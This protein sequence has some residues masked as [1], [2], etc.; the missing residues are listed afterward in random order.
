MEESLTMNKT[1]RALSDMQKHSA[2]RAAMLLTMLTVAITAWAQTASTDDGWQVIGKNE[3]ECVI[4]G[5]DTFNHNPDDVTVFPAIIDGRA[6]VEINSSLLEIFKN[7]ETVY[8]YEGYQH[9]E[10]PSLVR[11]NYF[12]P[13]AHIHIVNRSGEIVT[14]DAIPTSITKIPD[15]TFLD[16]VSLEKLTLPDGLKY[17]GN[18]AFNFCKALKDINIPDGVTNIGEYAFERCEALTS[19]SIPSSVTIIGEGAFSGCS[20]LT[21]VTIPNSVTSI[22]S[23]A[24]ELCSGLTSVTIPNSVTNIESLAFSQCSG[25]T[26]VTIPNSVTNIGECAFSQCS[27]LTSVTIPNSVTS[28]GYS[29]FSQCSSL[30]SVTI[31][32]S[33]TNIEMGTFSECKALASI[34]IP[35]SITNIEDD[36]FSGCSS[37]KDLYFDATKAQWDAVTKGDYWNSDVP[38]DFKEHWRCTVTF[39]TNNASYSIPPITNLWSNKTLSNPAASLPIAG[40]YTDADFTNEW[41]FDSDLVPGDMTLYAKWADPCAVTASTDA[42]S[43]DIPYGQEWTDIPVT[44]NSLT[45]GWFQNE[46]R[47]VREA[48]AV[49]LTPFIGTGA[50][51]DFTFYDGSTTLTATKGAGA[52]TNTGTLSETLTAAGQSATLWVH[53]P[54]ST[55]QS[56]AAGNYT[57]LLNYDAL[58]ISNADPVETYTYSLGSEAQVT[59]NLSIPEAATLTF[60]PNSGTG[61]MDDVNG[62]VGITTTL[63]ACTF[64]APEGKAFLCWNTEADGTGTRYYVGSPFVP[65]GS[66]TLYAEWGTDYVID[67]TT[68]AVGA[69]VSIPLGLSGQLTMLT[70]YFNNETDPMGLDL[71]LDGEKDLALVYE[72]VNDQMTAS[73][74]VL[75]SLTENY[76]FVLT[77]SGEEG[78]YGS[79]LFRFASE[80]QTVEPAVIEQL[81]DDNGTNNRSQLLVLKDGQ[82]H[83]LMLMGRTL[84]R[85][86]Y[87]NTLC[88]PFDIDNLSSTPLDGATVKELDTETAYDGHVTGVEGTTLYLNFKD[89]TSIEA[90]K[91]Y[92]VK[93][94]TTGADIVN[95][96]FRGVTVTTSTQEIENPFRDSYEDP[97]FITVAA[98]TDV[99]FSGG[100]FC[101]T[102]DP[103]VIYDDEHTRYYLGAQ[104][105]LYYPTDE[106]FRVNAFRAYF[107]LTDPNVNASAIVLNFGDGETTG[108]GSIDNGEL[109]IDNDDWYS[110]DGRRLNAKPT[111][112]GVYIHNGKKVLVG[113]KR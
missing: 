44:L 31:P 42:P 68:T 110:L 87:W 38:S 93:W 58:F 101:G 89:A 29:A 97:E 60:M 7:L 95:P 25:L 56:A 22:A 19:I 98:P 17:I 23:C 18:R 85:D 94:E 113:D 65:T 26:S 70:G 78:E 4:S 54:Q 80:G 74:Q 8:M 108:I 90:G 99:T 76:R 47:A 10:M 24:F 1:M 9:D 33:V 73:V 30:T 106:G 34:T 28:I 86:G 45:L 36:A 109:R 105:T 40:W 83:N 3:A 16:C 39:K 2:R 111:Q 51:A 15:N 13:F 67:L 104:N 52:H 71:N 81:Y 72:E 107:Q 79:V 21:S 43:I 59:I 64:T 20:S 12:S 63:P 57:G 103:T 49:A 14:E 82:P 6:V 88:L 53:I 62:R 66:M 75:T 55:W 102:Y 27:G 41:H 100:K 61:T 92:I 50:N 32:N 11:P 35:T 112:R 84:Y 77:T 5:F 91:P 96:V 46:G 37:L 69:S 48:D